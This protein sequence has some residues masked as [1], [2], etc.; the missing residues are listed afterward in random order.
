MYTQ[1][2]QIYV[3]NDE[4]MEN[5]R[6]I[7][8]KIDFIS[9]SKIIS[10]CLPSCHMTFTSMSLTFNDMGNGLIFTATF[11]KARQLISQMLLQEMILYVKHTHA[12]SLDLPF[13]SEMFFVSCDLTKDDR[14]HKK[15]N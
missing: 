7:L 8:I 13:L 2:L 12:F 14:T 9:K 1:R 11:K 15:K 5:P 10:N 3:N 6:F 4:E